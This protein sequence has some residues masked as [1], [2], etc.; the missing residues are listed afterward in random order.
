MDEML[1]E[2]RRHVIRWTSI[3]VADARPSLRKRWVNAEGV[4]PSL[5]SLSGGHGCENQA[6]GRAFEGR[7]PSKDRPSA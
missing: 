5:H 2:H 7:S 4:R 6:S 3:S 1:V